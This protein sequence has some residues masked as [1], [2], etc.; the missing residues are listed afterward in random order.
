MQRWL[1]FGLVLS[2]CLSLVAG[3]SETTPFGTYEMKQCISCSAVDSIK[4]SP[5]GDTELSFTTWWPGHSS[6][7][8]PRHVDSIVLLLGGS[9]Q[10]QSSVDD[11]AHR[12][13]EAH[14]AFWRSPA[15]A[16]FIVFAPLL[17]LLSGPNLATFADSDVAASV[18]SA[19]CDA[20]ARRFGA[21]GC[22]VVGL[23]NGGIASIQ[24]ALQHPAHVLSLTVF[25]SSLLEDRDFDA[26][27]R[28][29]VALCE[30]PVL[31][32]VGNRDIPFFDAAIDTLQ[33]IRD[34]CRPLDHTKHHWNIVENAMK[35][36]IAVDMQFPWQ[37]DP[38]KNT[39][40]FC[41]CARRHQE[42]VVH[43]FVLTPSIM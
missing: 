24:L 38:R 39:P 40:H 28:S 6:Q 7:Q 23:S 1:I 31:M 5:I 15:N 41:G 29:D 13:F 11:F 17:P 27:E 9:A 20:A 2:S 32:L 22:H 36:A 12:L 26:T 14:A 10:R 37:R 18:L 35:V 21:A 43:R 8:S 30:I 16:N 34:V 25:A 42:K 4:L 33:A 19:F 3:R